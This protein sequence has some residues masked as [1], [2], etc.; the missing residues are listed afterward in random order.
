LEKITQGT[1]FKVETTL[2][3]TSKT[4]TYK[5]LS[6]SQVFPAG[7]EISNARMDGQSDESSVRYQDFRDDRVYSY[8]DLSPGQTKTITIHCIAAYNGHY[9][10]PSTFASAMYNEQ[11][12]AYLPGKWCD[13]RKELVIKLIML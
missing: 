2:K 10:L 9:F 7:W 6:L 11:I 5:E 13:V 12:M 1:E 8:L 4:Q 3:N